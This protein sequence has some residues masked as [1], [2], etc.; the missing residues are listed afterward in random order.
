VC[1]AEP[2]ALTDEQVIA[3]TDGA[4]DR[5]FNDQ[6]LIAGRSCRDALRRVC[7]WHKARG[8]KELNCEVGA[9]SPRELRRLAGEL[10]LRV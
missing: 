5:A 2:P 9:M 6:V 3:D 8:A 10:H 7:Q 4:A 1:Q